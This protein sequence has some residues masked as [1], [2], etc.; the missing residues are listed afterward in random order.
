[1]ALDC[2][3]MEYIVYDINTGQGLGD[4]T[5]IYV[6]LLWTLNRLRSVCSDIWV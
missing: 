6:H 1:M 4:G 5:W 3:M 2:D